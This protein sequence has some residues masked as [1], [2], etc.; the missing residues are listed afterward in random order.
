MHDSRKLPAVAALLALVAGPV[1]ALAGPLPVVRDQVK[2]GARSGNFPGEIPAKV[3]FGRGLAGLS[4]RDGDGA[5]EIAIGAHFDSTFATRAGSLWTA[6]LAPAGT[7]LA[8]RQLG[9]AP[10]RFIARFEPD[11]N[12]GLAVAGLGDLDGDGTFDVAVGAPGDGDAGARTGAVYVLSLTDDDRVVGQR[13][14]SPRRSWARTAPF[15]WLLPGWVQGGFLGEVAPGEMFGVSLAAV[16]DLDGDSVPE[17]AVGVRES[18]DAG[19][20]LG[21]VWILFLQ[22]DATV[23][24]AVRIGSV[25]GGFPVE[26]EEEDGFG[27]SVA[28]LGDLDG[29]GVPDLAVGAPGDDDGCDAC[30]AVYVLFLQRD[31]DVRAMR[32]ISSA[33]GELRG[34]FADAT[35]FG[36]ALTALPDIDGDGIADLAVGA[37]GESAVGPFMGA[38]WLLAMD[39]DGAVRQHRKVTSGQGGMQAGLK[40]EDAF[41]SGLA[42]VGDLDGNGLPEVAVCAEGDDDGGTNSGA[43]WIL[44]L[45]TP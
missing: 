21:A 37:P 35:Q 31:G 28:A 30:G 23:K 29:D 33:D 8:A 5:P 14:I 40:A 41:G 20:A 25:A 36:I 11:D 15:V 6:E 19:H 42:L 17:L 45:G 44:F 16:G 4:D 22:S 3:S 13:K 39:R 43:V 10:H 2:I 9:D 24:R 32:K 26:L 27:T 1:M 12:F 34:L 7:V 38:V 18:S